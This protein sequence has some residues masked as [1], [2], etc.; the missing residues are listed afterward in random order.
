[1]RRFL[2]LPCATGWPLTTVSL[3]AGM[4]FAGGCIGPITWQSGGKAV[5]EAFTMTRDT[6]DSGVVGLHKGPAL[7]RFVVVTFGTKS[8]ECYD[9]WA[10]T[11]G[12]MEIS[13]PN[14]PVRSHF[15]IVPPFVPFHDADFPGAVVVAAGHWPAVVWH[16]SSGPDRPSELRCSL[17]NAEGGGF[18]AGIHCYLIPDSTPFGPQVFDTAEL[19]P[20]I[21]FV[22][23]PRL[24]LADF[25]QREGPGS[26]LATVRDSKHLTDADRQMVYRQLFLLLETAVTKELDP[27]V[28]EKLAP[29]AATLKKL[30]AR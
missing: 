26:L 17:T 18:W 4:L 19:T 27:E 6:S 28:R 25:I 16:S 24:C 8:K 29:A 14:R 5:A 22:C 1:M 12:K 13:Y 23:P 2:T 15:M 21:G 20:N 3:L 7:D 10:V 11:G 9:A 30:V